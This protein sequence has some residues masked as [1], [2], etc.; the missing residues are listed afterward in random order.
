MKSSLFV[1]L[2]VSLFLAVGLGGAESIDDAM[3]RATL[4]Y[5]QRLRQ[6][7]D[8]L[9]QT[10]E[11]IAKEKAPL[12]QAMRAAE[13]RIVAAETETTRLETTEE[14]A[15][16]NHRALA[17]DAESLR[18][19][20]SYLNTLAHD[21]LT[22]FADG[23]LPGEKQ[24]LAG[25]V[26]ALIEGFNDPT[27]LAGGQKSM[28]V[29]SL[30]LEQVQQAL[31]GYRVAGSSL[32][33]GDNRMIEGTF[34]FV[35]PEAFFRSDQNGLVGTVRM[36]EGTG[37]PVAYLLSSWKPAAAEAFFQGKQGTI[38][39]DPSAGKALRLKE[40]KGTVWQHINKGGVVS[41]AILGVG[42]LALVLIGIK[43]NDLTRMD[44]DTP[45]VVQRCL[46]IVA[47]GSEKEVGL[48]V[49]SLKVTTRE[50]FTAGL[51]YRNETKEMLEER[52][53]AVLLRQRLHYERR[54]PLLAVIATAAPLMGLLGTVTGMVRTFTLITV[55]GTGN[56]GKLASGISEVLVATE[57]GLLVAIPSLVVHGFLSQRIQKN[58]SLLER[59]ALEFVTASR[60]GEVKGPIKES[61]SA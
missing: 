22:A 51:R 10:R 4:E 15:V 25:K 7:S 28:E 39:A 9:I 59:Y 38:L 58:L 42:L 46:E 26:D 11:R 17:K 27:K 33:D 35:G 34:A 53:T 60:A 1:T 21:S 37:R 30:L 6:A 49:R 41:Y 18:K 2:A 47:T 29:A 20:E 12:L 50:L 14:Q 61:V 44:V 36:R 13:N 31:G 23:Q 5:N 52:L 57:L 8:E 55:F 3:K 54:L 48:A 43:I 32:I 56:A 19:T 16:E 45:Q 24:L 40:A